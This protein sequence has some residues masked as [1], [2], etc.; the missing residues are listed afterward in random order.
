MATTGRRQFLGGLLAAGLLPKP[1]WADVGTPA[2][3]AAAAT[4]NGR[5][6]LCGI[7]AALNLLFKLPLPARGHAAAGHPIRPE[8]VA[9][10]RRPGTFAIVID[11]RSGQE[12]ARLQSPDGR[13]FYGHGVFSA[14]GSMLYTTENNFEAGRG[15][16]GV[17]DVANGYKRISEWDSGGVGPHELRRLPLS[18][19]LVVAN[20]GID[21]HPDSGRSKLNIATMQPNLSYIDQGRLIDRAELP[22]EMHKNSIRHLA[23]STHGIIAFGMQWQGGNPAPAMVGT[24]R[25]NSDIRLIQAPASEQRPLQGYIGS[26]A[27]ADDGSEIAVTSPPG[28]VVQRYDTKNATLRDTKL[29][30]DASGIATGQDDFVISSGTGLLTRLN[31]PSK[32]EI[33]NR[34][35]IWDNHLVR[36]V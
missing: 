19:I 25:L 8:A 12:T 5:F 26:I 30:K 34:E 9:F 1:T 16:I 24:H 2:F 35:L 13:H 20:G 23:V 21:T 28:G 3:L 6:A 29:I 18:D 17:W 7:D 27:I 22:P 14:D 33:A 15:C 4:P 32:Q 36:L 10:A 31:A 11:C